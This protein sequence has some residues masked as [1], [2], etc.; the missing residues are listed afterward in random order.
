MQ[1]YVPNARVKDFPFPGMQ[2]PERSLDEVYCVF[3]SSAIPSRLKSLDVMLGSR[4]HRLTL[5]IQK[6]RL[7]E[8]QRPQCALA[9]VRVIAFHASGN[10]TNNKLSTICSR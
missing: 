8:L 3:F 1:P 4:S 7:K 9:N 10:D 6:R 5:C 2:M